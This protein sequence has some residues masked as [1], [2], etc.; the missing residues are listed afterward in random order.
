MPGQAV[1]VLKGGKA[2][3]A[4]MPL[5]GASAAECAA[6]GV[7]A[8]CAQVPGEPNAAPDSHAQP[9]KP[10]SARPELGET[11]LPVF[12]LSHT[13]SS[14]LETLP[15]APMRPLIPAERQKQ[16]TRRGDSSGPLACLPF[17]SIFIMI[18]NKCPFAWV[19]FTGN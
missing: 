15:P 14:P 11:F 3:V 10:D 1:T 9:P 8:A 16:S 2:K 6:S 5:T 18:G 13:I 4:P 19:L 7:P 12:A 17:V